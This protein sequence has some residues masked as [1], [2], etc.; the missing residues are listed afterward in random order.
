MKFKKF[1]LTSKK[2]WLIE[3]KLIPFYQHLVDG[4]SDMLREESTVKVE[5]TDVE[6]VQ[7]VKE[8]PQEDSQQLQLSNRMNQRE[9]IIS[10][11]EWLSSCNMLIEV[12]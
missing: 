5:E 11:Y 8:E 4:Y 10:Y 7:L 9:V 12:L 6:V 1:L 3:E 2:C